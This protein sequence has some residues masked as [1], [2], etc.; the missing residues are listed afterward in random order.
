M[1]QEDLYAAAF[2][3]YEGGKYEEASDCFR[4]LTTE[5]PED[6][7]FWMGLGAAHQLLANYDLS[8]QAYACAANLE[9]TNPKVHMHAAECF[10][11]MGN[12]SRAEEALTSARSFAQDPKLLDK[13]EVMKETWSRE[14]AHPTH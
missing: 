6:R 8:L 5:D 14:D 10:W 2:A 12:K 11:A 7:R 3:L 4:V 1:N 13:L 9:P